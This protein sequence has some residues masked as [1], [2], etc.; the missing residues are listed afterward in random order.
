MLQC[1]VCIRIRFFQPL[2]DLGSLLLPVFDH[3]IEA[4]KP[5][6]KMQINMCLDMIYVSELNES[7]IT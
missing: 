6:I 7:P 4:K 2:N 5:W 3:A 1:A